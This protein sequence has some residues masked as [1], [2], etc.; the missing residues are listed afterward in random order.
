MQ[1]Y[2]EQ[3]LRELEHQLRN[4]LFAL[5]MRGDATREETVRRRA[6]LKARL[7]GIAARLAEHG[8]RV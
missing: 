3:E 8:H 4:E 5:Q 6:K 2:D 7:A 1:E